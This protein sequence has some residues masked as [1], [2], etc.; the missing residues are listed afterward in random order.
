VY[1][2]NSGIATIQF[3]VNKQYLPVKRVLIKAA[4]VLLYLETLRQIYSVL[5]G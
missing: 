1:S 2:S 3:D 5:A 4:P